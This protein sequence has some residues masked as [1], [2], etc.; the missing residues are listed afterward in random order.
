LDKS[1]Y[2][3]GP[4]PLDGSPKPKSGR[5]KLNLCGTILEGKSI[6]LNQKKELKNRVHDLKKQEAS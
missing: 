4:R 5:S 1:Q 3:L 6:G 2:K